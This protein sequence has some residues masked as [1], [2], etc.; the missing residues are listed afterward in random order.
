MRFIYH[1]PDDWLH[2]DYFVNPL[3]ALAIAVMALNDHILKYRWPSWL[4]G[5][6]SD[7]MGVFYFPL[8]LCALVCLGAN[9]VLRWPKRTGRVAYINKQL[10]VFA[11][12]VT[13]GMMALIKLSPVG[14]RAVEAFVSKYIVTTKITPDPTD[15]LAL[16]MLP[17]TYLYARRFFE[18][19]PR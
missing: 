2:C 13:A 1:R 19:R 14:A 6:I 18:R 8:F 12:A 5:K 17:A 15:M 11:M 9:L 3:P 10:M 7:F 16:L 4:T